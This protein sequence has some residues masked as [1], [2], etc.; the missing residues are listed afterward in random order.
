MKWMRNKSLHNTNTPGAAHDQTPE[1]Y[2]STRHTNE[3][4]WMARLEF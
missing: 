4:Y 3:I 2:T 1:T